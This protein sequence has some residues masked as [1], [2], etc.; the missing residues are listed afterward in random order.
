MM[1]LKI[2]QLCYL[3]LRNF[4]EGGVKKIYLFLGPQN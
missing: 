2:G 4:K 1:M 3:H